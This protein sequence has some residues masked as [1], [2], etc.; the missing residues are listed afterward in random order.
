MLNFIIGMMIDMPPAVFVVLPGPEV[1]D[2]NDAKKPLVTLQFFSFH[3]RWT[4][5]SD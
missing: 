3:P 2:F 1:L 5:K 4:D